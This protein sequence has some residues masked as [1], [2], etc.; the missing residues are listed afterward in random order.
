M[1]SMVIIVN[2]IAS[3]AWKLIIELIIIWGD[4]GINEHYH[5]NPFTMYK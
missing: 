5:G 2:K 3:Y 1:Y 4:G